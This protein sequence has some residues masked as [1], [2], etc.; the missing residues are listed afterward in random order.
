MGYLRDAISRNNLKL[1]DISQLSQILK[2]DRLLRADD[3]LATSLDGVYHRGEFYLRWLQIVSSM[4][5]GTRTGR[6]ATRFIA[7]P[8]GGAFLIIGGI[9]SLLHLFSGKPSATKAAAD[10]AAE[11]GQCGLLA[12]DLMPPLRALLG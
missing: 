11:D 5:F 1:P 2:G 10:A 6:F 7:I 8:F 12:T 9:N 3:R 4:A